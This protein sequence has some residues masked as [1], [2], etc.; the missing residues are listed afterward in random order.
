MISVNPLTPLIEK[1]VTADARPLLAPW[2]TS[3]LRRLVSELPDLDSAPECG[4]AGVVVKRDST[5][6]RGGHM[7]RPVRKTAAYVLRSNRI[8][9]YV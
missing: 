3:G 6:L 1:Y 2:R 7:I 9:Q 8:L 4:T 5:E